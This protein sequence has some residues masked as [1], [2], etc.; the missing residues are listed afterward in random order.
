MKLST[1]FSVLS[2]KGLIFGLEIRSKDSGNLD[3]SKS[4]A[5][6]G[7]GTKVASQRLA[8]PEREKETRT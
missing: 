5:E 8:F 7:I 4:Q 3:R 1:K 2:L 6:Y